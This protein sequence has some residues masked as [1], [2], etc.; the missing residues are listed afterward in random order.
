MADA[1]IH[2]TNLGFQ[3][4]KVPLTIERCELIMVQQKEIVAV[5]LGW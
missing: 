2:D 4:E 1:Y 3:A 5:R